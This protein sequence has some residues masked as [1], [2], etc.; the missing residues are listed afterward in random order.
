LSPSVTQNAAPVPTSAPEILIETSVL[1]NFNVANAFSD[2][3]LDE[4]ALLL[5][6][7]QTPL[8]TFHL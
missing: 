3:E 5:K 1:V 7:P 8:Q 6:I 2:G 4:K